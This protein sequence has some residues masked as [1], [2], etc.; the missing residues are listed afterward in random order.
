MTAAMAFLLV[1]TREYWITYSTLIPVMT[2]IILSAGFE[3][4]FH[5]VGFS[6][7][8]GASGARAFKAVLQ[9]PRCMTCASAHEGTAPVYWMGAGRCTACA[10]KSDILLAGSLVFLISTQRRAELLVWPQGILLKDKS[11]KLDSMN[12]LRMMSPVALLLLLPAIAFLE[13]SAPAV[14]VTLM[15]AEPHFTVLLLCNS[16]VAYIVNFTNFQITKHTS[17]LTL[18]VSSM[19]LHQ[20]PAGSSSASALSRSSS[21]FRSQKLLHLPQSCVPECA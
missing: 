4:S 15:A 9:V 1:G 7:A 12:L 2:G 6:A 10:L 5:L 3:P 13:P 11:E 18:Q 19:C 14:A 21:T 16:S 17:A 8:M 20:T